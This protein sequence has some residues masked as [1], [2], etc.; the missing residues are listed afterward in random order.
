MDYTLNSMICSRDLGYLHVVLNFYYP[1]PPPQFLKPDPQFSKQID[2]AA[3]LVMELV[4]FQL[5]RQNSSLPVSFSL[6]IIAM[7]SWTQVISIE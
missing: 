3:I 4:Y 2:A 6:I 5:I 1:R 7:E